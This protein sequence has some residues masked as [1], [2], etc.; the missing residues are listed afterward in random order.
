MCFFVTLLCTVLVASVSGQVSV[1]GRRAHS[2]QIKLAVEPLE[3]EPQLTVDQLGVEPTLFIKNSRVV[4]AVLPVT[5]TKDFLPKPTAGKRRFMPFAGY[6]RYWPDYGTPSDNWYGWNSG[7]RYWNAPRTWMGYPG[8]ASYW[9][10]RRLVKPLAN[11]TPE[12][13]ANAAADLDDTI[14]SD[15]VPD[16]IPEIAVIPE[17]PVIP[18]VAVLP[19]E[20]ADPIV[21]AQVI[22]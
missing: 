10:R 18:E 11:S 16:P 17:E 8:S 20:L 15:V 3:L 1:R 12:L 21:T 14:V 22:S 7:P 4:P 19:E 9:P 5:D 6:P 2:A 13:E